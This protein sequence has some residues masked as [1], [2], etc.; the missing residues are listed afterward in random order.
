MPDV[1]GKTATTP[2][3]RSSDAGL[4]ADV[5]RARGRRR[6]TRARCSSRPGGGHEG[7][8]RARRS[9]SPSPRRRRRS[10]CPTSST[11]RR[12]RRDDAL[13]GRRLQGAA[14]ATQTVDT[15]DE[16]G[17]VLD[18]SPPAGEKRAEGL[19]GD[20]HRRA[21]STPRP[22]PTPDADAT[23]T[24]TPDAMRVAVLAGGRSSEHDVSLDSAAS[25]REGVAAAGHEV[26]A[27][28][29]SS[30]TAPGR[31]R[32]RGAGAARPAAGCSAPTSS[33]RCC[34]GRSA[35]T[36][37]SRACSSCSTCPTSARA[38]SPRRCAWTRSSSRRCWPP[39]ACRRSRYAGR[40]RARAGAP[41]PDAVRARAGRARAC[42][43][44]SSRRGWAR[45]SGSPRCRREAELDAALDARVRARR[46]W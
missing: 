3:A 46:R 38:C 33:S 36:A 4:Q 35:R 31:A 27:G 25:V 7:R 26:A 16:D 2:S 13:A 43:C 40:A 18:Q 28:D 32:R 23:P 30:A 11:R 24:P 29:G 41:T 17:V 9:S 22:T 34:T 44:S 15:P 5:H 1:V 8:T 10:R 14:C 12:G 45:R 21:A 37:R 20:D 6:R 19:D 42:R 39:P